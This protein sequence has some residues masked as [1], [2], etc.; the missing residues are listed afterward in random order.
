M[1]VTWCGSPGTRWKMVSLGQAPG[2]RLGN[3]HFGRV[4]GVFEIAFYLTSSTGNNKHLVRFTKVYKPYYH[5]KV[6]IY[7]KA[8]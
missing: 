5:D 8:T 1:W 6:L 7:K 3:P 2:V 4:H